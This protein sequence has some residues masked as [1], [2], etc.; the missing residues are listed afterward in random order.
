MLRPVWPEENYFPENIDHADEIKKVA[1]GVTDG[2]ANC[3]KLI[4]K[5]QAKT[6]LGNTA[7]KLHDDVCSCHGFRY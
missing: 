1:T 6:N 7:Y 3:S 2:R 5:E 4:E